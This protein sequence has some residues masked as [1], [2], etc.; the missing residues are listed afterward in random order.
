MPAVPI[1]LF[2]TTYNCADKRDVFPTNSEPQKRLSSSHGL[3]VSAKSVDPFREDTVY[4]I[5]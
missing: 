1:R 2:Q 3:Y 5:V 4:I